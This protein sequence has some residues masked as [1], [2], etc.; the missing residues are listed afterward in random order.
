MI[1]AICS[2]SISISK[3]GERISKHFSSY[4]RRWEP[5]PIRSAQGLV[6]EHTF[7][8]SLKSLFY[9]GRPVNIEKKAAEP[10]AACMILLPLL[11]ELRTYC[12]EHTIEE[13]PAFL[14]A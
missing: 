1:A 8:S 4:V 3:H 13:I 6:R 14:T 9:L 7:G 2:Q 5:P 11:D 12:Y 10:S